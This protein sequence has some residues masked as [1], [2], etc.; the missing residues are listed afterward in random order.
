MQYTIRSVPA[1]V[2][3]AIRRRA[4]DTGV[5]LNRA[6]TDALADGAGV[7]RERPRRDLSD[8]AGSW[9]KDR[10]V[11]DALAAQDVV[12]EALWR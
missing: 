10:V 6:A 7:G 12:D 1:A 3:A 2:D 8:I 5:S 11:E 9:K 4:R